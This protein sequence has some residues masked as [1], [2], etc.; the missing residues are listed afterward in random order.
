LRRRWDTITWWNNCSR[1]A[2]TLMPIAM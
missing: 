2:P 1:L